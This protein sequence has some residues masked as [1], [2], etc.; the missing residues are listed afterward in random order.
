MVR[1][2]V[3]REIGLMDESY[4]LY[5]DDID[6]GLRMTRA[7]E[8]ALFSTGYRGRPLPRRHGQDDSSRD[9]HPVA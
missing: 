2:G 5:A 9:Q 6:W 8:T 3:V 4:F 7:G 1:A